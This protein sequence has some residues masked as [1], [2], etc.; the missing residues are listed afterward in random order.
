MKL[1]PDK[2]TAL[3]TFTGYGDGFVEVNAQ[4]HD[5]AL[6][7]MPEGP[8][9]AWPVDAFESLT[10]AHFDTLLAL[11]PELVI[12]GTGARQ[13]FP[14]PTLLRALTAARIGV[15]AMDSRAACRTYNILMTEGRHV[16]VALLPV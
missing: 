2:A 13:R 16:L 10:A 7:M 12:L 15:E 4:R 14:H 1:H 9:Q 11:R 3:N 8:V 5:G 6:V